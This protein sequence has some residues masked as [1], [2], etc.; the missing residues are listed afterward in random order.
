[1]ASDIPG[2]REVLAPGAALAVPPNDPAALV[3]ALSRLV[4]DEPARER[5]GEAARAL[6][7]ENYSWARIAARLERIYEDVTRLAPTRERAA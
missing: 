2:Y 4:A 1:V 6:A 5:M 3:E 7:I